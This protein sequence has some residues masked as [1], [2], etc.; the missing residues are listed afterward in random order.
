[1]DTARLLPL[2]YQLSL[3]LMVLATGMAAQHGEATA[4][5]R[6]PALLLRPVLAMQVLAPLVAVLL[7]TRF[8]VD[9]VVGIALV[10]FATGPVPPFLPR[11][12]LGVNGERSYVVSVLA[13]SALLSIVTIPVTMSF[14][15][16]VF[17]L[18]LMLA[19]LAFAKVLLFSVVLPLGAGLLL[20][21][22]APRLSATWAWSV[23]VASAVV[24]VLATLPQLRTLL[25]A[26]DALA[27]AGAVIVMATYATLTLIIGHLLG[28]AE[29][30]HRRGLALSTA[31]RH[32]GIAISLI[33][34]NFT[35]E[36]LAVPAVLMLVIVSALATAPY[37]VLTRRRHV[38]P[39]SAHAL[40]P[41]R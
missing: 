16:D 26:F 24:L 34:A 7:A 33:S 30:E 38:P 29:L 21:R 15:S 11:K 6:K 28:G 19:P 12:E 9:R 36:A 32:P 39:D 2:G 13:T 40:P 4:L 41:P 27:D 31:T 1:M 3:S 35:N 18:P 22:I 5:L 37:V 10:A 25:P 20:A 14:L 23:G 17:G 8:P